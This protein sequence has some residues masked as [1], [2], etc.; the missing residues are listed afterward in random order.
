MTIF[1]STPVSPAIDA[2]GVPPVEEARRLAQM[3][4]LFADAT[5]ARI[6]Y[7]LVETEQMCVNDISAALQVPETSVSHALRLLRI[8]GVVKN[9]REGRLIYYSL[10]DEHIRMLLRTSREHLAHG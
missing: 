9:R 5:R 3:F 7:A 1:N 6:L 8:A 10:D 4:Q 2:A